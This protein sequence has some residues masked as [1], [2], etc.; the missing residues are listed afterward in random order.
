MLYSGSL[1]FSRWTLAG[2]LAVFGAALHRGE[3]L[4]IRLLGRFEIR[5]QGNPIDVPSRRSQSLLAYLVLKSGAQERREKLAGLLWPDSEESKARR[6]LRQALWLL[7]KSIGPE[8][9]HA[10]RITI[11]FNPDSQYMLDVDFLKDEHAWAKASSDVIESISDFAG[12]LLPGFYD[13]WVLR[14]R[15]RLASLFELRMQLLLNRLLEDHRW[16]DTILCG[17]AWIARGEVP[18]HAYR[19]LMVA[20]DRLGDTVSVSEAFHRCVDS[21][22]QELDVLPAEETR[23]LYEQLLKDDEAIEI[24]PILP[25]HNLRQPLT[26]FIG[27]DQEL[28]K[29]GG[30]LAEVSCRLLTLSGPGGI[31][32]TRLALEAARRSMHDFAH[33]TF[34]VPLAQVS[35]LDLL[36][37]TIAETLGLSFSGKEEPIEQLLSFLREK[38]ILLVLDNLEQI[39]DGIHFLTQ[40]LEAAPGVKILATTREALNIYGEWRLDVNGMEYP[41]STEDDVYE[42][43]SAIQLFLDRARMASPGFMPSKRDILSIVRICQLVGGMPLAIELASAWTQSLTC[44]EVADAIETNLDMLA[45]TKQDVPERQ[46]SLRAS[47]DYSWG[48]LPAEER[49]VLRRLAVLRGGFNRDAARI[50]GDASLSMLSSLM[51]KSLLRRNDSGR[52][53]IHPLLWRF[54]Y[55]ELT[56]RTGEQQ[57]AQEMLSSYYVRFLEEHSQ[58][59]RKAGH[60]AALAQVGE[61]IENI[62]VALPWLVDQVNLG[63]IDKVL[64]VLRVFYDVRG[65]Y[66]EGERTFG[67]AVERLGPGLLPVGDP[68]KEQASVYGRAIA[69]RAWFCHRLHRVDEAIALSHEALELAAKVGMKDVEAD[70]LDT[71]AVIALREGEYEKAIGMFKESLAIWRERGDTWWQGTELNCLAHAARSLGNLQEARTY[72]EEALTKFKET[73]NSWGILSALSAKGAIAR[74]LGD[75]EEAD[76]CYQESM[77]MSR[78][79]QYRGGIARSS[80]GQGRVALSIGDHETALQHAHTSLAAYTTLGKR[81]EIASVV[82]LLGDIHLAQGEIRASEE[83]FREALNLASEADS[84]PEM[85]RAMLGLAAVRVKEGEGAAAVQFLEYALGHPALKSYDRIQVVELLEDLSSKPEHAGRGP[86]WEIKGDM[87][88]GEV[89]QLLLSKRS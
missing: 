80:L 87:E 62:R 63:A 47:F 40:L 11:G 14:E 19:A 10:D 46:R 86:E 71:L 17:E 39:L 22:R 70:A 24:H 15:D 41:S 54:I 66:E 58:H 7:R 82:T 53:E 45:T 84:A 77:A 42:D 8:Y 21:L 30:C 65:W 55:E 28:L 73:E 1:A 27:R 52:F 89:A 13:N 88:I 33:G 60:D 56:E 85:L 26:S 4:E 9:F 6:Q 78:V 59:L 18:E 48:M 43:Y 5:R 69:S 72:A 16:Q 49:S 74:E 3:M 76:Q 81:I 31:G 23:A 51:E 12:E 61:E 75:L 50:V 38:K 57:I 36:T 64:E 20:H 25:R 37:P 29:I 2:V 67:Q 44:E 35:S 79:I 83:R 68:N 34:F 32:K